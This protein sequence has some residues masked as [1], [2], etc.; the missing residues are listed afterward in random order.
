VT[1][2]HRVDPGRLAGA[3]PL[4]DAIRPNLFSTAR[5]PELIP[6]I[7]LSHLASPRL[8]ELWGK[9][10][11]KEVEAGDPGEERPG[12]ILHRI[13]HFLD[14]HFLHATR[15]DF[16]RIWGLV[17]RERLSDPA[18]VEALAETLASATNGMA[19]LALL[20]QERE[21]LFIALALEGTF[22]LYT[23]PSVEGI[24]A[25]RPHRRGGSRPLGT[26]S[27]LDE[28]LL[29]GA[30][31]VASGAFS[32]E[33]LLFIGSPFHYALVATAGDEAFLVNGKRE[34]LDA[35]A[36]AERAA[37]AEGGTE[38]AQREFDRLF[39]VFDRFV[40]ARGACVFPRG[41]S[42]LPRD[43]FERVARSLVGLFGSE[44]RAVGQARDRLREATGTTE[45]TANT[46]ADPDEPA[47]EPEPAPDLSSL[48]GARS[49]ADFE[50][51]LLALGR[52]RPGS[53][54]DEALHAFRHPAVVPA[55]RLGQAALRGY[56][57]FL[58]SAQ[59]GS[60]DEAAQRASA[61]QGTE[62][63]FGSSGRVALP[64]EL[65]AFD[66]GNGKERRLLGW[67]LARLAGL[68]D[69]AG[70]WE[71]FPLAGEVP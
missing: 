6:A 41:A 29:E 59:V 40:T 33:D 64:D 57:A 37:L 18:E 35:A 32:L 55:E 22:P 54:F 68:E 26:T 61:V 14:R 50:S 25:L 21:T 53:L 16:A 5:R 42:T 65:L 8:W 1:P 34:V 13:Q 69:E 43:D 27:C 31:A 19:Q 60:V 51:R 45:A 38:G 71:C 44:V 67:T 23:Y 63:I 47:L 46:R 17:E 10:K 36:I 24:M 48:V 12:E 15:D 2:G 7:L 4:V 62:S 52:E 49:A 66:T 56:R 39:P 9:V 11:E 70:S 30:L 3:D 58:A 20:G 28:A